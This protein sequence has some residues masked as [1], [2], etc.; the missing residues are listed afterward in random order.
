MKHVPKESNNRCSILTGLPVKVK[1]I[2]AGGEGGRCPLTRG[3]IVIAFVSGVWAEPEGEPAQPRLRGVVRCRAAGRG[4]LRAADTGA[5][6]LR[7]GTVTA[8]IT[9]VTAPASAGHGAVLNLQNR[10]DI[11]QRWRR[12]GPINVTQNKCLNK[13]LLG[14]QDETKF[15]R[16]NTESAN[17]KQNKQR[18]N[19]FTVLCCLCMK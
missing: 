5:F 6:V 11:L 12:G 19:V 14:N 18:E 1:D 3:A 16:N 13:V 2:I 7:S 15:S 8:T 4:V 10:R 17:K 9:A